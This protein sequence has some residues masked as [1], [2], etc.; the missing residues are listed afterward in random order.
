MKIALVT[1]PFVPS[2][3]S[4]LQTY[5]IYT[6][7]KE[8]GHDVTILNRIKPDPSLS[9]L[10][11]RTLFNLKNKIIGV[12]RGPVFY[13]GNSPK[14]IMKNLTPFIDS[15][16]GED[17]VTVFSKQEAHAF[18]MSHAFDA[19]I[20]GSD[21]VWRPKFVP[22]VFHYY[23]DF[24]PKTSTA[25]RIAFCPSF[26]TDEWEYSIEQTIKCKNLLS[27]FNAVAVREKGGVSLC[28]N[29]LNRDVA[30]LFDPTILYPASVY[31]DLFVKKQESEIDIASIY[32]LD[33]NS[34]KTTI[35]DKVCERLNLKA[36]YINNRIQD[37]NARI[38][39]RIAPSL[40]AWMSGF[41]N[42]RF[43]ITDSFHA[44]LFALYFNKPFITVINESRGTAR[45][46][47]LMEELSLQERLVST[48]EAVTDELI[49]S[50]IDWTRINRV[51]E[52][53]RAES[54]KFLTNSLQ[55]Q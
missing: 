44:T 13:R 49:D 52:Q 55:A 29:Y 1:F 23:L 53:Q 7:L 10:M 54:I 24:L 31:F 41:F 4:I 45:F 25:K 43:I 21:Q 14:V 35:V 33:Y 28:A 2:H 46:H 27:N 48:T 34:G 6:K 15:Y 8:M 32:Y 18:V 47:S 19:F 51:L 20:V 3:G 50:H 9:I 37:Y 42:S 36:S 26:G 17:V 5:A 39:E 38:N 40:S 30:H 11:R 12:Y 22:D 16:F